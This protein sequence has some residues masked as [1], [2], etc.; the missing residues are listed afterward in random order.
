MVDVAA[1]GL[2]LGPIPTSLTNDLGLWD[3]ISVSVGYT[4]RWGLPYLFGRLYFRDPAS[5]K[6]LAVVLVGA[7][8]V[9]APLVLF[10]VRFSPHLHKW[11]Y[12]EFAVPF[13]MLR[14]YGGFRPMVFLNSP[15]AIG[16][17]M[18]SGA[19][20]SYW[21]WRSGAVK[22]ILRV[23]IPWVTA[24]LALS[25]V[26]AK[27]TLSIT[28]MLVGMLLFHVTRS[29]GTRAFVIAFLA[30]G[31]IYPALRATQTLSASAITEAASGI[32]DEERIESLSTRLFHEEFMAEK[33]LERPAFG[34]GGYGR[35]RV[36]KEVTG[37]RSI[38][39]GLWIMH[40]GRHGIVGIT[41]IIAFFV[42]GAFQILRQP[43]PAGLRWGDAATAP[44][45][46]LCV[47][48]AMTWTDGLF[49][50]SINPGLLVI[51][52]ALASMERFRSPQPARETPLSAADTEHREPP[53]PRRDASLGQGLRGSRG[54]S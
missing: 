1:L 35:A 25:T 42:L 53:R 5:L 54:W 32:Y 40:F 28:T 44:A 31:V 34:W 37:K 14:R 3:G 39:D 7:G 15:L 36:A 33:A 48:A 8:I 38:V 21:L 50:A 12:G 11:I 6:D 46:A 9:Y 22:R 13:Y 41:S 43:R 10:E 30:I 26:L 51:P 4:L 45:L 20:V 17:L 49:N 18:A 47:V 29:T 16:I 2:L 52:G 23:P 19:V 27:T 24:L